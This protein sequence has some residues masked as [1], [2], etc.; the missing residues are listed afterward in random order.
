MHSVIASATAHLGGCS[1]HNSQLA[2]IQSN[3]HLATQLYYYMRRSSN[4]A[5]PPNILLHDLEQC[6]SF[7]VRDSNKEHFPSSSAHSSRTHVCYYFNDNAFVIRQ[8]FFTYNLLTPTT[9]LP[10]PY[11]DVPNLHSSTSISSPSP[12]LDFVNH[13]LLPV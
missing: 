12:H 3:Q 1:F 6:L 8:K 9:S 5:V 7:S 10:F 2:S 11:L 4:F 13:K